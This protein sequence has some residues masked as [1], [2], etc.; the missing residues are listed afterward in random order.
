MHE[1]IHVIHGKKGGFLFRE[2][3]KIERVFCEYIIKFDI[4]PNNFQN[5]L[6]FQ[7]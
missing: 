7:M 5:L 6:T 3:H 1:V 2:E 4:F